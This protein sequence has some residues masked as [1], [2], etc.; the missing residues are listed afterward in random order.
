VYCIPYSKASDKNAGD[1]AVLS[2][3]WVWGN[4]GAFVVKRRVGRN[5]NRLQLAP[6]FDT[7]FAVVVQNIEVTVMAAMGVGAEGQLQ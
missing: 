5:S 7:K 3:C 2:V 6:M 4:V 1:R